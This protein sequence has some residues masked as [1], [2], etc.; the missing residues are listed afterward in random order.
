MKF[1]FLSSCSRVVLLVS[2][3]LLL[4]TSG[5]MTYRF[6]NTIEL[7]ANKTGIYIP[8]FVDETVEGNLGM[9]LANAVR[10]N[11]LRRHPSE[12]D[13]GPTFV[14]WGRRKARGGYLSGVR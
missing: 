9:E 4:L 1:K 7:P 8:V 11:V 12:K 13:A 3:G 2:C 5:C 10:G 14:Q 6:A